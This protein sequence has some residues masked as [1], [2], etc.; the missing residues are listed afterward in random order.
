MV[1]AATEDERDRYVPST[2]AAAW[3]R[4]RRTGKGAA[5]RTIDRLLRT[6]PVLV[7]PMPGSDGRVEDVAGWICYTPLRST[8]VVHFVYVREPERRRGLGTELLRA[9][10]VDLARVVT[11]T[12]S[13]PAW[14]SWCVQRG[15]RVGRVQSSEIVA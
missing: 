12:C 11:S 13:T 10:G 3:I 5:V 1:R 4:S 7:V 8:A 9:A 14:E 2:W 6:E 15:W